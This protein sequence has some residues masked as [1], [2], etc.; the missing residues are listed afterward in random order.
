M[1][2]F[3]QDL[4]QTLLAIDYVD[5][6][7]PL[8]KLMRRLRKLFGKAEPTPDELQILRGVLSAVKKKI[9]SGKN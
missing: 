6:N 4:E 1:A 2:Y 8:E 3:Y 5:T 7:K 9:S